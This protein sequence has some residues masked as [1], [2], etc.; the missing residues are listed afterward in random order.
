[1]EGLEE[2][3]ST[4]CRSDERW[5]EKSV[6]LGSQ[7]NESC[8]ARM[9]NDVVDG[10]KSFTRFDERSSYGGCQLPSQVN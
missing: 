3:R 1:M 10:W 6:F 4:D 7:R 5:N 2:N 9:T 8:E